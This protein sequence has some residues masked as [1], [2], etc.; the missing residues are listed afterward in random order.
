MSFYQRRDDIP[1]LLGSLEEGNPGLLTKTVRERPYG[2]LLLDEIEKADPELLNIF[3]TL[4]DEGYFTDGLEKR[5]DCKNLIVIATSNAGSDLIHEN[6]LNIDYLI[7]NHIFTPE[8]L[9]RF[10]GIIVYQ[11]LTKRAIMEIAKKMLTKIINEIYK[12]HQIKINISDTF[13]NNLVEKGYSPKFGA[14][15]LERV[16]RD[17]V[18]DKVAKLIL[19]DKAKEIK[20]INL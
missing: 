6:Q 3:L 17:E 7:K 9:N 19:E 14:R 18:E 10:D 11:A 13:L 15:N 2:V 5:V 16:I 12:I 8:F 20:T 4:L 1:N